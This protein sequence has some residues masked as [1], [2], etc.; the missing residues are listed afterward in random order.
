MLASY[1]KAIQDLVL[2][3]AHT[4][5]KSDGGNRVYAITAIKIAPGKPPETLNALVRYPHFTAGE[6]YRSN[7][8]KSIL[9]KANSPQAV[10]T[11]VRQFLDGQDTAFAF[12]SGSDLD[13]VKTFCGIARMVDLDFCAAFFLQQLE[14]HSFK[15]LWE[16]F[17]GRK[18]DRV[19]FSSEE[20][21]RLS[22]EL[23]KSIAGTAL[24]DKKYPSARAMRFFLEKSDTLM[25]RMLVHVC[26]NFRDYFQALFNPN[27]KPDTDDWYRFL[28]PAPKID[29]LHEDSSPL[30]QV[31]PA[32]IAERFKYMASSGKSFALRPSQVE[33]AHLVT[34]AM[35]QGAALCVEAGTGTGKTQGYLIPAMEFLWRNPGQRVAIATYTKSLQEQIFHRETDF[36]KRLFKMYGDIPV[37]F[38]K[39][40]S[41]YVCVEKLNDQYDAGATGD[42]LLSWLY[43]LN[44][45]YTF[46]D[47]DLDSVS[48]AIRPY[49]DGAFF[50][51][52]LL[53]AVSARQGCTPRH[54][55]CPAHVVTC[56]AKAAR[57][58]ITNHHK[59]AL[60]EKDPLLKGLYRNCVIDEA[61]HFERAVRGAFR[62][63]VNTS[64]LFNTLNY[65]EQRV[66]KITS[67]ASGTDARTLESGSGRIRTLRHEIDMLR[68]ALLSV[69]PGIN[70]WE[71]RALA[72]GHPSFR[73][74]DI[75]THLQAIAAEARRIEA[76][77]K[78][79]ADET[80]QRSLKIV[81]RSARKI[82]SGLELLRDFA[83]TVQI[84]A[85]SM[86]EQNSV[87]SYVVFAKGFA[88]FSA[89]VEVDGIIRKNIYGERDAVIYTAATLC[90][91]NRFDCFKTIVGLDRP[92]ASDD[93]A[94]SKMIK[95][96]RIPSHFSP[97]S[98]RLVVHPEALNGNF[99][100]KAGWRDR[101]IALL[102][103]LVADNTGRT[104]V[105][106]SSYDD[107]QYTAAR[108]FD[109]ITEAGCPLLVQRPGEPTVGLCDEF[110]SV[111]ES[112][113][114]GV[115]TFWYGVDFPGD[116]LTQ[117]IITRM[118]YP[119]PSDPILSARKN[120]VTPKAYW[121]RYYYENEIKIKQGIGRLIRT[122]TDRGKIVFLDSRF[123]KLLRRMNRA[124]G[125]D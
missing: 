5:Q 18:R 1:P 13:A 4:G 64:D 111:K 99:G 38:L 24:N 115:D 85:A 119:S 19:G 31:A 33:Y 122:D 77:L 108:T 124:L 27:V 84:I 87:V 107:L 61:N 17:H 28:K 7:L 51:S 63:E 22:I 53:N 91:D 25:G 55:Y 103:G 72:P 110:R 74:G 43:L 29:E 49:L 40:K 16:F 116:T 23:V 46:P 12:G 112:V 66:G 59:L 109:L 105:L 32:D 67:R 88:L 71:E 34:D 11:R 6:R 37:A 42:R 54:R 96:S 48:D 121:A 60:M 100:N 90:H 35:N 65:L 81:A 120:L 93:E 30:R 114:F 70:A 94:A 56:Q 9:E 117:V 62:D 78:I 123:E 69:N 15:R 104:L 76:S 20:I 83:E 98:M 118:P 73:Q 102:P 82:T 106:F 36:A 92:V 3:Y 41:S 58:V 125:R 2:V 26:R 79:V 47:A 57:L 8:S 75:R 95:T 80:V 44:N 97:E 101:V 14:S 89:P 68:A 52:H 45:V 50:F 86:A 113:L 10:Q 39:G 21:A